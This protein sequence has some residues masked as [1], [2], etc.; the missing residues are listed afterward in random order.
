MSELSADWTSMWLGSR[1]TI[2]A[3]GNVACHV[4]CFGYPIWGASCAL[5]QRPGLDSDIW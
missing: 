4:V 2:E 5:W 3:T 1:D